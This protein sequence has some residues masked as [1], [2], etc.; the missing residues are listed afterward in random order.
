M[1]TEI[2][3]NKDGI[4][5]LRVPMTFRKRGG[6]REIILPEGMKPED[7][8]SSL[9]IAIA[10]AFYWKNLL[11]TG[12]VESIDGLSK[13]IGMNKAHLSGLLRATMLAPDIVEVVLRGVEP[14]GLTTTHLRDGKIPLL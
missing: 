10:K 1:P 6:R 2:L 5:V 4:I 9:K 13:H 3:S 12:A 14:E 7:T 8:A 11:D